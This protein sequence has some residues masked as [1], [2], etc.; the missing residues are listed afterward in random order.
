MALPDADI[1]V[2]CPGHVVAIALPWHWHGTAAALPLHCHSSAMALLKHCPGT[3]VAA[4]AVPWHCPCTG[5]PFLLGLNWKNLGSKSFKIGVK[6]ML[7]RFLLYF[8]SAGG[9]EQ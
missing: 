3:V 5:E 2:P 1:A 4:M 7:C 6:V 9:R 8:S